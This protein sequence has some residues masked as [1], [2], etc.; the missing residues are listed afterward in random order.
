MHLN[1]SLVAIL[2]HLTA[3]LPLASAA[4]PDPIPYFAFSDIGTFNLSSLNASDARNSAILTRQEAELLPNRTRQLRHGSYLRKLAKGK[5]I[6]FTTKANGTEHDITSFLHHFG[7][8]GVMIVKDG[9][10]RLERY[11]YGNEPSF[12][13]QIQSCTKSFITT[14]MGIAIAQNKISLNDPVSKWIPELAKSP[15]GPV[16]IRNLIDMTSGVQEPNGTHNPDLFNDVYPRTDPD[17]VIKWFKTFDKV[18]EPGKVFNYYNPNY[19][20]TSLS[21]TRAIGEPLQNWVSKNIWE[22]AGMQYDGYM[23]VTGAGQVDGHGGLALTLPDM[24]RYG[25][26]ILD[27]F[28]GNGGPRVPKQWFHDISSA[29]S[30]KGIRGPG[31]IDIVPGFGYQTGWWTTPRGAKKYQLGNDG[32]FAALGTYDQAVYVIPGINTTIVLQ[33]D[34]PVHYPNLFYFGQQFATAASLALREERY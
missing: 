16:H 8:S 29:S 31:S 30:S 32:G 11:Q 12:R 27:A 5:D 2:G 34:N 26:F 22:P 15:W 6:Y 1:L 21:L 4:D 23:R 19:Y 13:N 25:M 24:A 9:K 28:N 10:I 18:A 17:A 7:I 14:S 33:S 3:H 20:V